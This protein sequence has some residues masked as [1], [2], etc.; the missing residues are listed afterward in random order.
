MS[1]ILATIREQASKE[2][3]M[4]LRVLDMGP[5]VLEAGAISK[6]APYLKESLY[7]KVIIVA[8]ETTYAIAGHSLEVSI[9]AAGIDV[10]VSIIKPNLQGDVIAD[11]ASLVQL[12]LDIKSQAAEAVIA[13]GSGTLHDIA[14]FSGYTTNVPFISLPTAPSV[15]GFNSKG[16]P[17]ILRGDK[18]TIQSI[19]PSAIFADLDILVQAPSALVAA[20]FGDMLG[21]F[22]SLFDWKFGALAGGEPYSQVVADLTE[23][24]LL[25]CVE[26]VDEIAKRSP[27]GIRLLTDALLTSGFAMLLFG[28]SHSA[29]G[30]EHHLSHYWEMEFLRLER[31]Q[32]LHG[33]KVGVACAEISSFYHELASGDLSFLTAEQQEATRKLISQIP[34]QQTIRQLIEA[35]GGPTEPKQLGIDAALLERSLREAHR[36]RPNRYTLLR[37]FNER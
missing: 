10:H 7:H 3:G 17:V 18:I 32:I 30:A 24:A 25:L 12:M 33:A 9:H 23:K 31:R 13:V 14:R 6:V 22:T 28:Q 36:I 27:E 4:D 37:T 35:V 5:V 20:G 21:K 19:G 34:D 29:S 15:D 2:E 1:D 26:H 8:D 11:E 16:A